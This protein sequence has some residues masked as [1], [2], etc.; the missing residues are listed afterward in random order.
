MKILPF[1]TISLLALSS[2]MTSVHANNFKYNYA[3]I[4]Y[5]FINDFKIDQGVKV[6]GSYDVGYNVNILGSY[7]LSTSSESNTDI[8]LN[9][10]TL[11][12]GYHADMSDATDVIAEIGLFN[13]SADAK[14]NNITIT[15]DDSGYTLSAGVRH[16]LQEK[17]EVLARFDH[18]NSDNTT[19]TTFTLGGRYHINLRWSVGVD[20][21]TGADDGEESVTGNFRWEF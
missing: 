5:T 13:T 14:V 10:Y 1:I 18:R 4:G 3:Q 17:I 19:D 15:N 21:N 2:S 9:V 6:S 11:G 12:L 20:F 16:K 8:D 7:F